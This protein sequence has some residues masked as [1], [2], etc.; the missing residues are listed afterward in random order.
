MNRRS[1]SA[2]MLSPTRACPVLD[3]GFRKTK[4]PPPVMSGAATTRATTAG[5]QTRFRFHQGRFSGAVAAES[6]T[7]P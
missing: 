1:S 2:P 5:A 7:G 6:R 3:A 4:S